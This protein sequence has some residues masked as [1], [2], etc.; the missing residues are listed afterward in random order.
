MS[1]WIRWEPRNVP[2]DR[3]KPSWE[4][5]IRTA[6]GEPVDT[7]EVWLRLSRRRSRWRVAA[8]ILEN[9]HPTAPDSAAD[10]DAGE[11]YTA[12]IV[13]ALRSAGKPVD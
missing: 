12:R 2:E 4:G 6:V 9:R 1:L 5:I 10:K 8:R 11:F 13:E 3:R 7:L